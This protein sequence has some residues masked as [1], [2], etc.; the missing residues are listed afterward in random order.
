M[1]LVDMLNA[2]IALK[3]RVIEDLRPSALSNLG[4]VATLEILTREFAERSG[5]EVH[6]SLEPI[7]LNP[8]AELVVYRLVQEA[9]T[10]LS[11]YAQAGHLWVDL[12]MHAGQVEISV[13]D[14]GV[15]FDPSL[16]R[17][18][19]HGL[20]GMRFRIEAEGGTLAVA[21]APGHG[22]QILARLP[23][24]TLRAAELPAQA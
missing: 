1:H 4:L 13:R 8:A 21:S 10:N 12:A 9:I 6:C 15:G 24:S 2:G 3:R 11:K 17:I 7:E 16:P 20:V 5:V 14:D 19:S 23:A 22:T 18:S